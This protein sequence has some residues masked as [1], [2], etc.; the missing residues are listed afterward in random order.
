MSFI[1]PFI[2]A[3]I[4]EIALCPLMCQ[5]WVLK[6]WPWGNIV[7]NSKQLYLSYSQQGEVG[8]IRKPIRWI[9]VAIIQPIVACL[10]QDGST[11]GFRKWSESRHPK[12][13]RFAEVLMRGE[14][15]FKDTWK[16]DLSEENGVTIIEIG[17]TVRNAWKQIQSV[18]LDMFTRQS[19]E[20][21]VQDG[22]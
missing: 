15:Q 10:Y 6:I 18:D 14:R 17:V 13:R 12:D 8:N 1:H 22:G 7:P 4:Q 2:H 11:E 19:K 21:W 9:S 20:E 3:F 16:V 5:A